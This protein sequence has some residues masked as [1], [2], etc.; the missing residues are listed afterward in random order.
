MRIRSMYMTCNV[1][2]YILELGMLKILY[3]KHQISQQEY[4]KLKM[5]LCKMY[6]K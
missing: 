1:K 5:K 4:E 6:T 2:K 3:M